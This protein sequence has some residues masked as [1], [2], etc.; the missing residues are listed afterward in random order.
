VIALTP[1]RSRRL[2][3]RLLSS[4]FDAAVAASPFTLPYLLGRPPF[5]SPWLQMGA[6]FAVFVLA[7]FL[8][9]TLFPPATEVAW[10]RTGLYVRVSGETV[11]IPW[12][13]FT[14]YRLTWTFPRRLKV[15]SASREEPIRIDIGVFDDAQRDLLLAELEGRTNAL[16]N[17]RLKLSA[18]V[19]NESG[20][21]ER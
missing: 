16:P 21:P 5:L 3:V 2:I 6:P 4:L 7:R 12:S 19:P 17:T 20:E 10:D 1:R 14:R 15:Y 11:T 9:H 8:S 13:E 18:P